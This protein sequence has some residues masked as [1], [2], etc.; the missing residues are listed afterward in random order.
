MSA[1]HPSLIP[2]PRAGREVTVGRPRVACEA[3]P[4]GGEGR[5]GVS[6]VAPLAGALAL[7]APRVALACPACLGSDAQNATFLK[8]GSFFV[9]V[10]FLVVA[11]VLYVL[12]QA[13]E[14]RA[15][16]KRTGAISS[17]SSGSS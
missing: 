13:P 4:V 11:I 7:L 15:T 3:L 16:L 9:L 8:I 5:G 12:R 10:P 2:C 14:G 6:W 17:R 1:L